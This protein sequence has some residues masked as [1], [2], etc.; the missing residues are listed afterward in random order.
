LRT[1]INWIEQ[2]GLSADSTIIDVGGG[3]STLVDDLLDAGYRSITVLDISK[4][5]LSTVQKRLGE[6]SNLV[7]WLSA[8][9]TTA[10]LPCREYELWH[11]R[12]VFHF[13]IE[14]KDRNA[15]RQN[16]LKALQLNGHVIIGTFAPEAPPKCSG[17]PVRRYGE[18]QLADELGSEFA[19]VNHVKDLHI[20]PGG[21]EQVYQYCQFR[22]IA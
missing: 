9:I 14:S 12:A 10:G 13:L 1:S 15:Y 3:A 19:L 20:T 5:A 22:R 8:D 7:S 18:Q 17:L 11:D 16:L 4:E 2:L 21:V 6:K